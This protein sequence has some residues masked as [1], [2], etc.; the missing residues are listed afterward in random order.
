MIKPAKFKLQNR[1]V[2][3]DIAASN[4]GFVSD[5][6]SS[7]LN[8][9]QYGWKLDEPRNMRNTRKDPFRAFRV[10][11]VFRGLSA[12]LLGAGSARLGFRVSDFS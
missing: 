5:F 8:C 4:F 12:P 2:V 6:A 10:F 11:S 7:F 1:D 3:L 9:T